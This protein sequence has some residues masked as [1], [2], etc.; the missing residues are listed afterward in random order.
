MD[1]DLNTEQSLLKESVARLF[2]ADKDA[3]HRRSK[4]ET[5]RPGSGR[6]SP[7]TG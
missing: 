4:Q 7:K 5:A 6:N 3:A 2:A 1:F